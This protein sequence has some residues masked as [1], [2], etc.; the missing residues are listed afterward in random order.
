MHMFVYF[1]LEIS[2]RLDRCT[3][4]CWRSM[5]LLFFQFDVRNRNDSQLQIELYQDL[6]DRSTKKIRE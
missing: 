1:K 5:K 4:Q 2:I 3:L 6:L